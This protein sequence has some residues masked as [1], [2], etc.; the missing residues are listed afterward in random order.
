ME[1]STFEP[2]NFTC[3]RASKILMLVEVVDEVGA[4]ELGIPSLLLVPES[5]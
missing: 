1:K 4:S 5:R 3:R 2:H